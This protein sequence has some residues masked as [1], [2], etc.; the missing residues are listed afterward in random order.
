MNLRSIFAVALSAL[1]IVLPACCW[2]SKR[3]CGHTH[4]TVATEHVTENSD[5]TS[6]QEDQ[7]NAKF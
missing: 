3:C 5:V 6:T 4:E 2:K 1:I 7:T